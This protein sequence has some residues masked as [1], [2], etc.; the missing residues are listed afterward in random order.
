[1]GKKNSCGEILKARVLQSKS[2]TPFNGVKLFLKEHYH[3]HLF[4]RE[5]FKFFP[6]KSANILVHENVAWTQTITNFPRGVRSL[7]GVNSYERSLQCR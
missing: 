3:F 7:T 2:R 1:M 4:S 6:L 5:T